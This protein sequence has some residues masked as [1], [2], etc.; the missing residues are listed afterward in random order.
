MK[1]RLLLLL[2]F[3][4]FINGYSQLWENKGPDGG[5]FKDFVIHPSNPDIVYAGSDDG[6]GVWKTTNGG[7]SWELLTGAYPNFTGWHIEMDTEHPD[8]L[9][10]CELY[11]RYGIL[12]TMDGGETF[13]HQTDGFIHDRDFQTTQLMIYP[14]LGDT[15]FASTGEGDEYG[16]VG[17]GVF[18]SFDGGDNW[19]YAGLQGISVHCIGISLTNRI[20]AGTDEHGLKYSD[21]LGATWIQHPDVPDTASMLQMDEKNGVLVIS[22]AANGVY[23]SLDHGGTFANIGIIGESNFDV[24]IISTSPNIEIITTGFFHPNYFT[25]ETLLWTPVDDPLLNDQ[26]LIGVEGDEDLIYAGIF[27]STQIIQSTDR[28]LTWTQLESNPVATEI[29]AISISPD[30]DYVYASLQNSYNLNGD[31]YNKECLTRSADA[32][33]TWER[34]GPL[35]HGMDLVMHPDNSQTLFLGTFAQGLFKTTDGFDTWENIYPGNK[36]ILDVVIDPDNTNHML[37]SELN[38]PL[39]ETGIFKS[40]DGGDTWYG[41]GEDITATQIAY[42]TR[43]DT[44]YF[45]TENGIFLS[46]DNGETIGATATYLSGEKVLSITYEEPFLYA[47]TEEGVLY[48][49]HDF[50]EEEVISGDWNTTVPTEVRNLHVFENTIIVGLN[51]AEQDTLHNLNGGVWLSLDGGESWDDFTGDLTNTNIFGNTG[52]V[53]GTDGNLWVG[54]YGQGIF[55]RGGLPVSIS[56]YADASIAVSIFPN[57]SFEEEEIYVSGESLIQYLQ[58]T[59]LDGKLIYQNAE[60][61]AETCTIP[62]R[63]LGKGVFLVTIQTD[64]AETTRKIVIQ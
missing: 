25:S 8:T 53:M 13:E 2:I 11:G 44:V 36:L 49:I 52:M 55:K 31:R 34:T 29:R 54:T 41:T 23:L 7:D 3:C 4:I 35:A 40:I 51:G 38:I 22:G 59:T 63:A 20:F 60:I 24:S 27:S 28:G 39:I 64:E 56:E 10:F 46:A 37:L 57:P 21:D 16:R 15:L 1:I 18:S 30:S 33:E 47:G 61:K 48:K 19:S 62:S 14:G 43:S 32:G 42:N 50:G 6:G 26:I 5:F 12:K 9:Y 58:I 17:N 45:S